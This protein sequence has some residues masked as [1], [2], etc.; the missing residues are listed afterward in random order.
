MAQWREENKL[1]F[2]KNYAN[3]PDLVP[4]ENCWLSPK[5]YI[6][7]QPHWDDETF[8]ELILEG[9][10][11]VSQEYVNERVLSMPKRLQDVID[12]KGKMARW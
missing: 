11:K 5:Q 10:E 2:Y 8:K 12:G 4:I 9:W 7:S 6:R 1:I 3:S